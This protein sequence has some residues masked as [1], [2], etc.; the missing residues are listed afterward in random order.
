MAAGYPFDIPA[1]GSSLLT[2]CVL[3]YHLPLLAAFSTRQR[4]QFVWGGCMVMPLGSLRDDRYGIVKVSVSA[5][6]LC[7][8]ACGV[9]TP[10]GVTGAHK[11]LSFW[12]LC[13]TTQ[14]SMHYAA[15][16]CQKLVLLAGLS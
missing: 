2:Y 13:T 8:Q 6:R 3:A 5:R 16:C 14:F 1:P 12:C 10:G 9:H 15:A 11:A 7:P 4:I